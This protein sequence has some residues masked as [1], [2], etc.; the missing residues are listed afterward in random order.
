MSKSALDL[1]RRFC[2]DFANAHNTAVST[3]ILSEDFTFNMGGL[4]WSR[5]QYIA[6]VDSGN[7]STFPDFRLVP[8]DIINGGDWVTMHCTL[9]GRS[10]RHGA[11]AVW[12]GIAT[13]EW[14]GHR[15]SCEHVEEDFY[16]CRHQLRTGATVTTVPPE[17]VDPWSM[18]TIGA[19]RDV[20]TAARRWLESGGLDSPLVELDSIPNEQPKMTVE[21]I[22]VSRLYPAGER[23][24]FYV[25]HHGTYISGLPDCDVH[26]GKP[27]AR[28][29]GGIAEFAGGQPRRVRAVTNRLLI[30]D[31]LRK[32]PVT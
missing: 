23:V 21:R 3:E 30:V 26:V 9:H 24:A 27:I 11:S 32:T 6:G 20:E 2:V 8:R 4:V 13:F 1:V 18:P 17:A 7:M 22:E 29:F 15:I 16:S 14:D 10:A 12:D 5:A 28:Y 19:D 25:L 31:Q